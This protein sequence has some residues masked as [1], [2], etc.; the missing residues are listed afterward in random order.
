MISNDTN[1]LID[2]GFSEFFLILFEALDLT[3]KC[4][5]KYFLVIVKVI[6]ISKLSAKDCLL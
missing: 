4:C 5:V 6:A 2:S 3:L 1:L